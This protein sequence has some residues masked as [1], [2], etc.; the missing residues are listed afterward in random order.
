[1]ARGHLDGDDSRLSAQPFRRRSTL[2]CLGM[3]AVLAAALSGCGA[4][5]E[6]QLDSAE[7][8][9][10]AGICVDKKTGI[11]LEDSVCSNDPLPP[12]KDF[13]AQPVVGASSDPTTPGSAPGCVP[14]PD[15]TTSPRS[16]ATTAPSGATTSGTPSPTPTSTF[17]QGT[18][19]PGQ[20]P[21]PATSTSPTAATSG[22]SSSS[23]SHYRGGG[24][25]WYFIPWG[26]SAPS[27]GGPA[28]YGSFA[29]PSGSTF[30]R[31]GMNHSGGTVTSKTVSGGKV[32]T[33]SRGGFGGSGAKG[34]S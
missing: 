2:V 9:T 22:S 19:P 13:T 18:C 31:G 10:Y 16:P 8:P 27:V 4:E 26:R 6:A 17:W 7:Q 12:E 20:V 32:S 28:T 14:A 34:G 11:R 30:T 24:H 1:M 23:G 29:P 3:T 25:G 5:E 33:S 15:A 21:A